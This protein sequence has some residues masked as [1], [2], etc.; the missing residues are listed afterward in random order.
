LENEKV[1][2]DL[3]PKKLRRFSVDSMSSIKE[4]V[5]HGTLDPLPKALF[6]RFGEIIQ[7][8]YPTDV[9]GEDCI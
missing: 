3:H 1:L 7:L 5:Y 6:T 8:L 4:T 9:E 2:I